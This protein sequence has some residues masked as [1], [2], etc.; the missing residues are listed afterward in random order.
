MDVLDPWLNDPAIDALTLAIE[1]SDHPGD[2]EWELVEEVSDG[3]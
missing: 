2:P 1:G 3:G